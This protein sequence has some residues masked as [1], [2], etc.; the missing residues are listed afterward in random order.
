M[1]EPTNDAPDLLDDVGFLLSRGSSVAIRVTNAHLKTIGVR[2]R[3]FAVLS[4]ASDADGISQKGL[5]EAMSLD[6][7]RIVVIVDDLERRGLVERRP[8]P[9]DRRT[10]LVAPTTQGREVCAQ[11]RGLVREAG[12]EFLVRL[13]EQER[14]QLLELLRKVAADDTD[15]PGGWSW[16]T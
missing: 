6:P 12:A 14:K 8:D 3:H 11:A 5:A 13:D 16:A 9:A 2:A 10:R 7:S 1:P 15:G 4:L